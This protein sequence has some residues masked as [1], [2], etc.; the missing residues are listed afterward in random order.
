MS[1]QTLARLAGV[2]RRTVSRWHVAGLPSRKRGRVRE[3]ELAVFIPWIRERDRE[4]CEARI[5]A[6]A[7]TPELKAALARKT[8]AQADLAE[9]DVRQRRREVISVD[10]VDGILQRR[11]VPVREHLLVLS[12]IAYQR[13][14]VSD[15]NE[16]K[17][18]EL[19]REALTH[20]SQGDDVPWKKELTAKTKAKRNARSASSTS[21]RRA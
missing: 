9:L 5:A 16:E 1:D 17:L 14:L 11:S 15:E 2:D 19:A 10:E 8:A 6:A 3:T 21:S 13:G 20:L 18:D 7:A 12:M 4:E